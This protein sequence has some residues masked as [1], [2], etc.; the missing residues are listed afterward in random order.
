MNLA[1]L[2]S[3]WLRK[4]GRG[5]ACL[6]FLV[7]VGCES[8]EEKVQSH[9][10]DGLELLEEGKHVK[11]GLEFR[12]ALQINGKF[13]PALFGMS[14]VEE[15]AGNLQGVRGFLNRVIDLD[16]KHFEANVRL[17]RIRLL[18]G[19]IDKA[20][21]LSD[22][23]MGLKADDAGALSLRAAVL[24]KLD[25]K[26]GAI[27]AAKKSLEIEP[28]NND[29]ISVL[30]A[31]RI[32]AGK[33][34]EAIAYLDQGLELD[35][36]SITLQLIKIQALDSIEE[37]DAAEKVLEQLVGFYPEQKGFKTALVRLY[38]SHER[39]EAAEKLVRAIAEELPDDL[40]ASLDVVRFVRSLRGAEAGEIEFERLIAEGGPHEFSF[41]LGLAGLQFAAGKRD[42]AKKILTDIINEGKS[43][44]NILEAK[45]RLA[46]LLIADGEN[47]AAFDLVN[48]VLTADTKNLDALVIRAS[49]Y[50][51]VKMNNDAAILDLRT[52][53]KDKPD[54]V[55]ALM[56]LGKAHERNGSI[57]LADDKYTNAFQVSNA[58]PIVG[59]AYANF[60]VK[61]SSLE[62]AENALIKVLIRNPRNIRAYRSLAQIRISR[63][64]WAGAQEIADVLEDLG[65]DKT[66]TSQ[67]KGI[68]LQGQ[69]KF[70][71][72]ID[73]FE[74]AQSATPEAL[75]P[76]VALVRAYIRDGKLERAETFLQAVLESSKNNLFAKVLM[77]QLHVL[78]GKLDLA[79][80]GLKEAIASNPDV[81]LGYSSLA[82]LYIRQNKSD[83]AQRV[84][85]EGLE[86]IPQ[87]ISLG[88]MRGN[89]LQTVSQFDEAIEEYEKLY[90]M[91]PNSPIIINNL[92]SMLTER[93][94]DAATIERAY[95]MS[96]RF[97]SSNIPQFKDTLGWIQYRMGN[98]DEATILLSDA[99]EKLPNLA[100][101]RYHLGMAHVASERNQ[102][103]IEEL[104]KALEL[105]KTQPF[106]QVEEVE[107]AL[108]ELRSQSE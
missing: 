68:A 23:S 77:A 47:D 3:P 20:L 90:E 103:A 38:I 78:N 30:A 15:K 51:N 46:E 54:S 50:V 36:K 8:P 42:E 74:D 26:E 108:K 60:L 14:M 73:A 57:E 102:S 84:L 7:I 67:I 28:G 96:K 25:D 18:E 32:A 62:R 56:L 22:T 44:E 4:W 86:K 33:V 49:L 94:T 6:A 81:A 85:T 41:R 69:E 105:S 107:K 97:K 65:D 64:N 63:Q 88:L 93:S 80:A 24:Y 87:N 101:L 10:E 13:V 48:V 58:T 55:R 92:A 89:L 21:E 35:E 27:S 43:E 91:N 83:E 95:E 72:S 2:N 52:V 106:G 76:M 61:N 16:P 34:L 104:E 17:G 70:G 9:Y 71:Q 59:L 45:N 39:I 98:I 12:N 5:L 99:A 82:G 40:N 11:A 19:R 29:A 37:D 100:I 53:L 1:F 31:E 79:E 75:R 66:L